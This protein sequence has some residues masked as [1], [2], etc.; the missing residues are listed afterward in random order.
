MAVEAGV[1]SSGREKR[2][3]VVRTAGLGTGA[4]QA[5]A[6]EGLRADDGA[7]LVAVDVDVA[8]LDAVGDMLDA[9]IDAGVEAEG[10]AV[11]GGVDGGDHRVE[12]VGLEGRDVEDRAEDF[13]G[14]V[15][16]CRTP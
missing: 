10:E 9:R 8:G 16:R 11:A 6:T 2:G 5:L 13:L 4:G 14:Q 7:D 12:F 1:N 15:A 3:E